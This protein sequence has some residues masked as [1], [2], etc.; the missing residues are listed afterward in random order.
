MRKFAFAGAVTALFLG[1]AT[2][3]LAQTKPEHEH[4]GGMTKAE[5][6]WVSG[7]ILKTYKDEKVVQL[8]V[9]KDLGA[10]GAGG[11]EEKGEAGKKAESG[12]VVMPKEGEVIFVHLAE[13]TYRDIRDKG[14]GET[15]DAEKG[16]KKLD[17]G[18]RV[19][20]ECVG[21]HE[22]PA[23]KD[24]PKDAR[25]GGNILVYHCK[26]VDIIGK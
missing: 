2:Y 23:P 21:T 17:D 24:F 10:A 15:Y 26:S 3:G 7:R 9:E 4:G 13:A 11:A 8:K 1:L 6:F 20:C 16:F 25:A 19:R 12:K 14:K 5:P 18:M 22:L